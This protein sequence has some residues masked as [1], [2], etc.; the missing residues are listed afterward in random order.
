MARTNT[1]GNFLTDVADA[2]RTK[3]GS[4][5]LIAAEDFDTEIE[6]L[7]SGGG[8]DLS[9][10]FN[11]T[12]TENPTSSTQFELIKKL[13]VINVDNNVTSLSY[14][15][16]NYKVNGKAQQI[17]VP[18]VV[19]GNNVTNMSYMYYADSRDSYLVNIDLSGLDTSNVTTMA[20]MFGS[21]AS[22][23]SLDLSNFDFSKVETINHMFYGCGSL[24]TIDLRNL[25]GVSFPTGGFAI[26]GAFYSCANLRKVDLS[27]FAPVNDQLDG[28]T[29]FDGCSKLEE[30]YLDKWD[31]ANTVPPSKSI[32]MFT[33]CGSSLTDGAVTKVYV[34]DQAAQN[35][36]LTYNNGHPSTWT[37]DNV[38][39]AGSEAD[40]RNA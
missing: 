13:P 30:I 10:Y 31:L 19:C 37:T 1:L 14:L 9:E 11:N 33:N 36:I 34:K 6:N 27:N 18:K 17:T 16:K 20:Y 32:S 29:A 24:T 21:R 8:A 25:T 2:I 26:N 4:Q 23:V 35:W 38:I 15:F 3:K 7:P 22:V 28:R 39:I 40:L 12:I 5:E